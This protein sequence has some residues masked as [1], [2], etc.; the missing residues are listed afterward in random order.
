MRVAAVGL[1]GTDFHIAAGHANYNRDGRGRPIPLGEAPQ[2]LG[3]EIVGVVEAVGPEV[4]D[5]AP[6]DRVVVD[7]GRSCVSEARSPLCE[8]CA[9][10]D[11]HQCEF[12]RE[13]GITG[14][15]GGLAEHLTIPAVNA[16]RVASDVDAATLALTEP[17]GCVVHASDVLSRTPARYAHPGCIVILGAG[18][19]GLLFV[20]YLRKVLRF[21]GLLLVSEP[22]AKK[23]ALAKRFGAE[24]I[25]A[26]TDLEVVEVVEETTS[27]RR[28]ELLI[29]ATGSGQAFTMIPSLI[30]KQATVLMYGHGHAGVDLSALNPLQFLEPTLLS[31]VGASGGHEGDGR[32]TTYVRA[33][34]LI[35]QGQVD[36]A[37][38]ITHRYTSLDA[39][40]RAFAGEHKA[41]GYVKGVCAFPCS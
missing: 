41:P 17:L 21:D 3:H 12:Y 36:V 15:P 31:P 33:L 19:G 14:L 28:A 38:M 26:K 39:V 23:R 34:R 1:C 13:H 7:Q 25:D 9:S 5:L 30:R 24:T 4:R 32:P 29:E 20:Q 2:I 40:V 37:S 11:S 8:Y 27:G 18:P 6:G 22:N 16:V 35:E 10:G